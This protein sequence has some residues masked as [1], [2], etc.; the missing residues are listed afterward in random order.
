MSEPTRA[1]ER[2]IAELTAVLVN[3]RVAVL[4]AGALAGAVTLA[5]VLSRPRTYSSGFAV[6]PRMAGAGAAGLSSLAA[7]F[8]LSMPGV[9]LTQTPGFYAEMATSPEVLRP[10]LDSARDDAGKPLPLGD[11][12]GVSAE[13][14]NEREAA[15]LDALG[16][17]VKASVAPKTG[18]VR[19]KVVTSDPKVSTAL[20]RTLMAL[21][22]STTI[23]M[24]QQQAGADEHFGTGRLDDAKA[25]LRTAENRLAGYAVRN[26]YYAQDP[27]G[28]VEFA[29]LQRE[30]Q[31]KQGIVQAMTQSVEQSRVDEQRDTPVLSV[32]ERVRAPLIP[33]RR[34]A[35]VKAAAGA[36]AAMLVTVALL[37]LA[38]DGRPPMSTDTAWTMVRTELATDVRRPWRLLMALVGAGRRAPLPA[39]R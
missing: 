32:V 34:Y 30:V 12:L 28:L 31:L 1:T 9:D 33:D 29:R 13:T 11:V 22:Q 39:P 18:L 26:R 25:Q 2:S 24:R 5:L 27:A 7:Q 4:R 15:M 8:G 10:L 17:A 19:V 20:A 23:R 36:M 3:G 14:D 35:V 21:L 38:S 6:F 37:L 16:R